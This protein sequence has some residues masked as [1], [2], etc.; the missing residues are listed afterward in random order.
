VLGYVTLLAHIPGP[1]LVGPTLVPAH[2]TPVHTVLE[3]P[4][5]PVYPVKHEPHVLVTVE[6]GFRWREEQKLAE[7][8]EQSIAAMLQ[9]RPSD[10]KV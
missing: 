4:E 6:Q 1:P 9:V 8:P 2:K 10:A 3:A 7:A 5:V